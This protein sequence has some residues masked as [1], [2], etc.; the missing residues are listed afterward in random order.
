MH[1]AATVLTANPPSPPSCLALPP[2]SFPTPTLHSPTL[3]YVFVFAIQGLA[4]A[5]AKQAA[6][7]GK[8]TEER[9]REAAA[10]RAAYL[11]TIRERAA[12]G[13]A[14]AGADAGE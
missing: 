12:L 2:L 9:L 13:G 8:C 11:D 4:E 3:P 14:G 1:R 6:V 7:R 5:A 10:R